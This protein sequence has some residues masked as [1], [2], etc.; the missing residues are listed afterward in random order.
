[1]LETMADVKVLIAFY[2]RSGSTEALAHA[3]AEGAKGEEQLF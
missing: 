1:M 2:S 3:I